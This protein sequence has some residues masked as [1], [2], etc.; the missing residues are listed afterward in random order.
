[1]STKISAT[2]TIE[3][4]HPIF[5]DHPVTIYAEGDYWE[6]KRPDP[7]ED[8]RFYDWGA[9]ITDWEV[10]KINGREYPAQILNGVKSYISKNHM[11]A[12]QE[13]FEDLGEARG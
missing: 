13:N 8:Q 10:E 3:T 9:N 2:F 4:S 11:A 1:M 7:D 5:M 12:V 6:G